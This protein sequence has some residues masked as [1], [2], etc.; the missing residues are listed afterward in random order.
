M[1]LLS[2]I[3]SFLLLFN[4]LQVQAWGFWA[5]KR[6]NRLAVFT[7]PPEMIKFFKFHIEYITEH[8]V[9]PDSRR[10]M[11]E[12]EAENH[13]IDVD[14]YDVY[15]FKNVPRTWKDAVS[16]YSEDTLR[17]YGI[18]PW[19]LQVM[20][21]RLTQAF[22]DRDARRI[23]KL[24]TDLGH[25]AGD[26]NVPLH[27]TENY[28]GQMSGQYGIHGFW[29][30]RLPELYGDTYNYFVGRA[31]YLEDPLEEAWNTVFESH[32][33]LDSVFGFE[34]KLSKQYGTDRKFG[35]ENRNN[36]LTKVYSRD[37]SKAYHEALGGQVERRMRTT[38][39]RIG[40][41]W[42]TAWV[43]AGQPNLDDLLKPS[44]K[45]DKPLGPEEE[46]QPE[47]VPVKKLNII[48]REASLNMR[49][50]HLDDWY[51][52]CMNHAMA[53]GYCPKNKLHEHDHDSHTHEGILAYWYELKSAIVGLFS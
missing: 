53:H 12:G 44:K 16:K 50:S 25:Y 36:V 17:S 34:K 29:E 14:H 6:L 37:F 40:S 27:T 31:V 42:Y 19:H 1:R 2:I 49:P 45:G 23:L 7:L 33:A 3:L 52:C 9:D 43:N 5:H 41:Y 46:A 48:D 28:N 39:Y 38:I 30:S 8:A 4:T 47:P 24:A 11:V 15:P 10:Y 32:I 51:S 18:V 13:Y 26:S 20:M 21:L 22:R 35:Y